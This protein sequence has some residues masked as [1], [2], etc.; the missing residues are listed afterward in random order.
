M[1]ARL[2]RRLPPAATTFVFAPLADNPDLLFTAVGRRKTQLLRQHT[3]CN[4]ALIELLQTLDGLAH[5]YCIKQLTDLPVKQWEFDRIFPKLLQHALDLYPT[6][7]LEVAAC[8][9]AESA[10]EQIKTREH[11]L[12]L[13]QLLPSWSYPHPVM[14]RDYAARYDWLSRDLRILEPSVR[15]VL[16]DPVPCHYGTTPVPL[17]NNNWLCS[18]HPLAQGDWLVS[19]FNYVYASR[20]LQLCREARVEIV[21][22]AEVPPV[23][24]LMHVLHNVTK[25]ARAQLY[26]EHGF[27]FPNRDHSAYCTHTWK[28]LEVFDDPLGH[29]PTN[30]LETLLAQGN[31]TLDLF[32]TLPV[33]LGGGMRQLLELPP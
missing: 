32:A 30:E 33:L 17:L 8:V 5:L 9:T 27:P 23:A 12:R 13:Q 10:F 28:E 19:R 24:T 29:P 25:V 11:K 20:L 1:S 18:V 21:N 14:W 3:V 7:V 4:A 16:K 15:A 2:R 26:F 6:R 31:N 22:K